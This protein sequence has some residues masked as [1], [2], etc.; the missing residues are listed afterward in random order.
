MKITQKQ[1]GNV[2]VLG[3]DGKITI[4]AGDLALRQAVQQAL[5]GG[6]GNL[7]I[8]LS[9]VTQIDSS[10]VGELV[11]AYTTAMNRGCKLRL[12]CI[13]QKVN[14]V[15]TITQLITVFD[16]YDTED[17]AVRSFQ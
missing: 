9:R 5:E 3:V 15:L 11:S 14:D 12:A 2:T 6:T 10:G 17:E 8:N 13:P 4:G 7:V 1:V 16:V